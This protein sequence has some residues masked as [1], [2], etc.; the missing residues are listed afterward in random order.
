M[1]RAFVARPSATAK[2]RARGLQG[3][4]ISTPEMQG[5]ISDRCAASLWT[6]MIALSHVE[7]GLGVRCRS[8]PIAKHTDGIYRFIW[9]DAVEELVKVHI[10]SASSGLMIGFLNVGVAQ[11]ENKTR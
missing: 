11:L 6:T 10:L 5:R 1:K 7:F 8:C 2:K 3:D 9:V 4:A